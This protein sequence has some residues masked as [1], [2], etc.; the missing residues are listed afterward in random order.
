MIHSLQ[1]VCHVASFSS[2]GDTT[3][4][5][6]IFTST[7]LFFCDTNTVKKQVAMRLG[8]T[9]PGNRD[10]C[11][12]GC[13]CVIGTHGERAIARNNVHERYILF[14]TGA[15]GAC[16]T[17]NLS[18][19]PLVFSRAPPRVRARRACTRCY[20]FWSA[21]VK[22]SL[23]HYARLEVNSLARITACGRASVC[24]ISSSC[25]LHSR[26]VSIQRGC[27][28]ATKR[29]VSASKIWALLCL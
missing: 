16:V 29:F 28:S 26:C 10:S 14:E 20:T 27:A 5:K 15:M 13:A 24:E 1:H 12:T 4:K 7:V 25:T 19:E 2:C 11:R 22:N 6:H 3:P 18:C 21:C 23:H 17:L 9:Y 8:N